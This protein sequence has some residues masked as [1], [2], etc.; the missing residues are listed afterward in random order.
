MAKR[1]PLEQLA[2]IKKKRLEEAQKLLKE[3]KELLEAEIKT[4]KKVTHERDKVNEHQVEKLNQLRAGLDEGLP[5]NK[6]EQ[7]RNY[8]KVVKEDL[9]RKQ[10]QV[11]IQQKKV[12]AAEKE[13]EKAREKC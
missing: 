3:K 2:I 12:D 9:R 10:K 11:E 13:V 4:L 8:L 6:I 7:M 5:S 1:Y